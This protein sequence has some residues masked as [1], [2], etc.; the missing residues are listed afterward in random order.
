[1]P[2]R[3]RGKRGIGKPTRDAEPGYE[4]TQLPLMETVDKF[5]SSPWRIA[6]T[7]KHTEKV[8]SEQA[9]AEQIKETTA[10]AKCKFYNYRPGRCNRG[11]RCRLPLPRCV[12]N[13]ITT[14]ELL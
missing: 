11:K 14:Y 7:A 2:K 10:M 8:A 4:L 5:E 12:T 3:K 1:M 13:N 6:Q 9:A